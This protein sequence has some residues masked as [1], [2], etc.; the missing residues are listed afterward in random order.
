M[1]VFFTFQF[2]EMAIDI[3]LKGLLVG[4]ISSSLWEGGDHISRVLTE[5]HVVIV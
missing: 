5:E 4:K 1:M 2:L 3:L